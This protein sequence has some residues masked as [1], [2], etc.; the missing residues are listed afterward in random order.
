MAELHT[1]ARPY[2]RAAFELARE[3]GTLSQW[4]QM[5]RALGAA[6]A[7]PATAAKLAEPTLTREQ[8]AAKLDAALSDLFD[9]T[10]RNFV[11]VL[12]AN[13]RL[14]LL[15]AVAEEFESLKADAER[16]VEVEITTA[17]PVDAAQQQALVAAVGRKLDRGV[18]VVW[19]I[20]ESLIGGARI[21]AGDLVIDASVAG[22][23]DRL[24]HALVA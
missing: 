20:D 8:L 7:D 10:Q 15:P 12:A 14:V 16:R 6:L 19:S 2:G 17:A 9:Q 13:G 18:D 22:E 4:S 3:A 5:L 1:L 23:L 24:R 21:K 11:R